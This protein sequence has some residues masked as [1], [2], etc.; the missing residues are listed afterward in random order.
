MMNDLIPQLRESSIARQLGVTTLDNL[1]GNITW[2]KSK[3]GIT[4]QHINTEEEETGTESVATFDK[5]EL[6]P[7]PIA[8]FVP[9]TFGM[10]T[11][12]AI[13]LD[14]WVKSEIATQ[15]ALLEDQSIFVG[16]GAA[17]AP[18]GIFNH[19]NVSTSNWA[20]VD[21]SLE[22]FQTA[23]DVVKAT[24]KKFGQNLGN[25]GWATSP[26]VLYWLAKA[27]DTTNRAMFFSLTDGNLQTITAPPRMLRYPIMDTD[28]LDTGTDSAEQMMFG[29]WADVYLGHWGTLV[30]A[31]SDQTETNFRKLRTTVRGVW[32]YDVGVFHADAFVKCT[33]IPT[34]VA[35]T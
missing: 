16:T 9:L 22:I 13:A 29:P 12:P 17:S 28:Q 27:K 25:L 1:V 26:D 8:A 4:A 20:S 33:G 24:R 31:M 32:Q 10:Q 30:F 7:H 21:T 6:T 5:I 19:P 23:L 11:Q 15:M 3:G 35:P 14:A 18:R 2:T 34:N